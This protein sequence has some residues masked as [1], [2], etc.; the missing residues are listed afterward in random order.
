MCPSVGPSVGP[1]DG[2]LVGPLVGLL[3]GPS[4]RTAFA[5]R[6]E[7]SQRTTYQK[8]NRKQ[9]LFRFFE[10]GRLAMGFQFLLGERCKS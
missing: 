4:V 3:L 2:P 6:A 5:R 8:K 7:T 9:K 10:W 1:L